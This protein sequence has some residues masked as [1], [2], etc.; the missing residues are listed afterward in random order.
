M[1][2]RDHWSEHLLPTP[3]CSLQL[4]QTSRHFLPNSESSTC[5]GGCRSHLITSLSHHISEG[6][7]EVWLER[8]IPPGATKGGQVSQLQCRCAHWESGVKPGR[9]SPGSYSDMLFQPKQLFPLSSPIIFPLFFAFW[10]EFAIHSHHKD[11]LSLLH[12]HC[13]P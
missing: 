8:T 9:W 13:N 3:Y 7:D 5:K 12:A 2:C 11:D 10:M 6:S 4:N 1:S